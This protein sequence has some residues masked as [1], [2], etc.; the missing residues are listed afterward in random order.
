MV[1]G[2]KLMAQMGI[3]KNYCITAERPKKKKKMGKRGRCE[4][5]TIFSFLA[6]DKTMSLMSRHCLTTTQGGIWYLLLVHSQP[7]L[8]AEVSGKEKTYLS[9]VLGKET[10]CL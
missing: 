5:K 2:V 10:V 1:F 7:E 4:F 6:S 9:N 3:K 8:F